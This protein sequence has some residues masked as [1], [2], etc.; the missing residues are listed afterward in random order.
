MSISRIERLQLREHF[1]H[2][3][4]F[5]TIASLVTSV[6]ISVM[7]ACFIAG[8]FPQVGMGYGSL[9][10]SLGLIT[11]SLS[12]YYHYRRFK[13][14]PLR[15]EAAQN[16]SHV[17][18]RMIGRPS[19]RREPSQE[20]LRELAEA[21]AVRQGMR[22]QLALTPTSEGISVTHNGVGIEPGIFQDFFRNG[23][24]IAAFQQIELQIPS[25]SR[26]PLTPLEFLYPDIM[27][28]IASFLA[29]R[30][31]SNL[32]TCNSVLNRSVLPILWKD[33]KPKA[34][35][36]YHDLTF[37]L[38]AHGHFIENLDLSRNLKYLSREDQSSLIR[39]V[40]VLC[41]HLVSLAFAECKIDFGDEWEALARSSFLKQMTFAH[42]QFQGSF[43]EGFSSLKVLNLDNCQIPEGFLRTLPSSL[44]RL[45]IDG[46]TMDLSHDNH[47]SDLEEN[48]RQQS[49]ISLRLGDRG[50]YCDRPS[51]LNA[52]TSQSSLRE[53]SLCDQYIRGDEFFGSLPGFSSLT[54]LELRGAHGIEHEDEWARKIAQLTGLTH[55]N[56][57]TSWSPELLTVILSPLTSLEY[58]NLMRACESD[59]AHLAGGLSHLKT[60]TYLNLSDNL[61]T[62]LDARL[63]KNEISQL[64]HLRE[65]N[66][67]LNEIG[68]EGMQELVEALPLSLTALDLSQ[69]SLGDQG[70]IA[71]SGHLNQFQSLTYL[72]LEGNQF[73]SEGMESL[74]IPL[75][76]LTSLV[77]LNLSYNLLSEA[78]G[79]EPLANALSHL[80]SLKHLELKRN[81]MGHEGALR[82]A[83]PLSQLSSLIYLD[84]SY[85][86]LGFQGVEVLCE[87]F[88]GLT[89]LTT[90]NLGCNQIG[91]RGVQLFC[92]SLPQLRSLQ[93]LILFYEP[94]FSYLR[95]IENNVLEIWEILSSI[96]GPTTLRHLANNLFQLPDLTHVDEMTKRLLEG[97]ARRNE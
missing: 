44:D 68:P 24:G 59:F 97:I 90:L 86:H 15:R 70:I 8:V 56:I 18:G 1:Q 79:M 93:N 31:L 14:G 46:E 26:E 88:S 4:S 16:A 85:N 80:H 62:A 21:L 84:I 77:E 48:L 64:S 23:E 30:D 29:P 27:G 33:F 75:G 53:L 95:T 76:E 41:P 3:L 54:S 11:A 63:L 9:M 81:N 92:E 10:L 65:L 91:L 28:Y 22:G 40:A 51:F 43:C 60:L 72:N 50:G 83:A 96:G 6:F 7:G 94:S 37:L 74:A 36:P 78:R 35:I 67:S 34:H 38:C 87:A 57:G 32:A 19:G 69:C 39:S 61:L 55:L 49:L 20:E 73:H 42:V 13:Q 45:K 5:L 52:L 25:S 17:I 71:L 89:A 58:L 2:P 82:L 12:A 66:L 47:V